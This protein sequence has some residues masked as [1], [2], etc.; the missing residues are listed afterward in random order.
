MVSSL[1]Y[2]YELKLIMCSIEIQFSVK[3][4]TKLGKIFQAFCQRTGQDPATVRF[5]FNVSCFLPN[6]SIH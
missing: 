5:T 4:T 6:F 1:L 2:T 3:P